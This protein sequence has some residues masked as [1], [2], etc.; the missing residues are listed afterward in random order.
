MNKV[1]NEII[2]IKTEMRECQQNGD[3]AQKFLGDF[4]GYLVCDG[5]DGYNKLINAKRCGCFAHLRRKLVET[6]PTDEKLLKT[7]V[8]AKGFEQCNLRFAIKRKLGELPHKE[9]LQK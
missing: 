8:A 1:T 4:S 7:S 2:A 5:F 9:C 3:H 6:L